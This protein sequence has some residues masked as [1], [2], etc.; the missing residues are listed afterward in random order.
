MAIS[1]YVVAV[2]LL[3][4]LAPAILCSLILRPGLKHLRSSREYSSIKKKAEI[5]RPTLSALPKSGDTSEVHTEVNTSE[6]F[7]EQIHCLSTVRVQR[8]PTGTEGQD[9]G[10]VSLQILCRSQRVALSGTASIPV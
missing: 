3:V 4:P 9:D 6:E 1:G 8:Q 5:V 7:A 2:D 10:G